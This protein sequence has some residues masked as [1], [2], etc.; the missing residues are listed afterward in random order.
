MT[1]SKSK[2]EQ[3]R[4]VSLVEYCESN[5]FDLK[6]EGDGNYRIVGYS[7]L[8]IKDNYFYQFGSEK[9]GNSI[10]FC[11]EILEMKFKDAIKELLSFGNEKKNRL[12]KPIANA[13]CAGLERKNIINICE[14]PSM[15]A[16]NHKVIDYLNKSRGLPQE[17]I[18]ELIDSKLLYQDSRNNCV[19]P[20]Y[21]HTG[22]FKGAILRGTLPGKPFKGRSK[23]SDVDYGW[24]L[25]PE[26]ESS[27]VIIVEAPI[28][29]LSIIA[30]HDD[31][32]IRDRYILALGGL[33]ECAVEKFLECHPNVNTIIIAVD[34]D[35]P[36]SQFIN[37]VK[38][39]LDETYHIKVNRPKGK[40]DWNEVLLAS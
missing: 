6:P 10:D 20:C 21:D 32:S 24:L 38:N 31:I 28:D 34:N 25:A 15:A 26:K 9:K 29:A 4:N 33:H 40:K 11:V 3:A 36:A 7:G 16:D 14:L 18:S 30:L 5:G 13:M 27:K 39:K 17:L 1:I 22:Q 8:I 37:D 35:D 19:F 12:G 23:G 2:I